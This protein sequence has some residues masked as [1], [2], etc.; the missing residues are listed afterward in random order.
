MP[1]A[2]RGGLI[3]VIGANGCIVSLTIQV[4]LQ[5]GYRVRGTV[6]SMEANSWISVHYGPNFGLVQVQDMNDDAAFDSA[7]KGVDGVAHI[8]MNMA[9][10]PHDLTVIDTRTKTLINVLEAA[11]KEPS[12]KR[13]V[14]TSSIINTFAIEEAAQPWEAQGH[15]AA[16]GIVVYAAAKARAE[17]EARAWMQEHSLQFTFNVVFSRCELGNDDIAGKHELQKHGRSF[18]VCDEGSPRCPGHSAG[19]MLGKDRFTS[20][21]GAIVKAVDK[22]VECD[23]KDTPK[24]WVEVMLESMATEAASNE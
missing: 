4:L 7:L 6:R 14:W 18:G 13:V 23:G 19:K 2:S 5:H 1:S 8:A 15:P 3:L 20:L 22:V 17:Q 11:S 24:T 9:L 21:E 16:R 10:D 12:V